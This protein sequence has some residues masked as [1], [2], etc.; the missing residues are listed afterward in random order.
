MTSSRLYA[1]AADFHEYEGWQEPKGVYSTEILAYAAIGRALVDGLHFAQN[2][3]VVP[4]I[5]DAPIKDDRPPTPSI[6]KEPSH[7]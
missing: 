5:V 3:R 1:V 6:P 2:L 4:L 7:V